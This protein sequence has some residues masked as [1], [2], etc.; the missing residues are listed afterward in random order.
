MSEEQIN[1][2]EVNIESAKEAIACRDSLV[3][4]TKNREFKKIIEDGYFKDEASRIVLVKAD[5]ALQSAENQ[6]QL[7]KQIIAI[8]ELRQYFRMIFAVGAEA[9]RSMTADEQT[10]EELLA[11]GLED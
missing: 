1:Q 9:E 6:E 11:E 3:K 8:G 7:D 4:L 2:I 10:R 5:P